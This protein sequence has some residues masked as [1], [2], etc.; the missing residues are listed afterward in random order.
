MTS[1]VVIHHFKLIILNADAC[2]YTSAA[3][4]VLI[5]KLATNL[6]SYFLII[7]LISRAIDDCCNRVYIQFI[8]ISLSYCSIS[9]IHNNILIHKSCWRLNAE[10]NPRI[11]FQILDDCAKIFQ[12]VPSPENNRFTIFRVPSLVLCKH[13]DTFFWVRMF[14]I[15]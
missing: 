8:V 7:D 14:Q 10:S 13:S 1:L 12:V 3:T 2:C 6:I 5:Q 15:L 11:L 4:Y 9:R